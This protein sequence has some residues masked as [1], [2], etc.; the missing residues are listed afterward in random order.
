[1]TTNNE[2]IPERSEVEA[3]LKTILAT[4]FFRR[5]E[6]PAKILALLVTSTLD[7]HPITTAQQIFDRLFRGPRYK[8][9][10]GTVRINA[11]YMRNHLKEYNKTD[12]KYDPV[13]IQFREDDENQRRRANYIPKFSYQ[14]DYQAAKAHKLAIYYLNRATP[15]D[16]EA[17]IDLLSK[18]VQEQPG[19]YLAHITLAETL[20]LSHFFDFPMMDM[21]TPIEFAEHVIQIA[22]RLKPKHWK[23]HA[24]S[25]SLC[26][27][28]RQFNQ[29][30]K[31]YRKALRS[32]GNEMSR[33]GWYHAFL[34]AAGETQKAL[35]LLSD[36]LTAAP[37]DAL[38]H[39]LYGLILHGL[40]KFERAKQA[41]D[42]AIVLDPL[43]WLAHFARSLNSLTLNEPHKALDSIK[44][45]DVI[46][47]VE[48]LPYPYQRWFFSGL[49]LLACDRAINAAS[50]SYSKQEYET[51]ANETL[52]RMD[53]EEAFFK[54]DTIDYYE[55]KRFLAYRQEHTP[56][57]EYQ[58]A[59]LALTLDD[60]IK[61]LEGFEFIL[62]ELKSPLIMWLHMMP[63]FDSLLKYERFQSVLKRRLK[64]PPK[65]SV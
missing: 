55:H 51:L 9:P 44:K 50:S 36:S 11:L 18:V 40:R 20:L 33:Y 39:A 7:G 21:T 46:E 63:V 56:W 23:S 16:L 34:L 10:L 54:H 35:E 59:L 31:H 61:L 41:L 64:P 19:N 13:K 12:G 6:G 45:F 27:A 25:G 3:Q 42:Y 37:T 48:T 47:R 2:L 5:N 8:E 29:A 32:K 52:D 26:L 17:A 49:V 24:V 62:K 57:R 60:P 38:A 43:C 22:V 14:P 1:M 30:S 28:R 53:A 58:F 65:K 4:D 15:T